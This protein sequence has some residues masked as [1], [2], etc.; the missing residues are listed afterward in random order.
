MQRKTETSQ[1]LDQGA[2]DDPA[3]RKVVR[4]AAAI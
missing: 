1:H 4:P 3:K 2:Q